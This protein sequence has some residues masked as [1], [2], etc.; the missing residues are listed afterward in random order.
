MDIKQL[1]SYNLGDAVKFHQQLNPRLWT[2]REQ[3]RPEIRQRLLLIAEDF[4]TSLGVSD[5]D[6]RDVT[7]SGSNA[8]Y[9]YTSHSDIDLHLIIDIPEG[10]DTE[11]YRE[12]FNAKKTMYNNEHDITVKGIPVELYVQIADEPVVSNGVYSVLADDWLQIPQRRRA[13]IDDVS[14]RSKYEDLAQ[15]IQHAIDTDSYDVI[16]KLSD[17]IRKMRQSGLEQHGEFGAENLAF[18]ILRSQGDIDKLYK[19]KTRARS[20]EL[21]LRELDRKP[22]SYGFG[23]DYLDEVGLTPDGTNPSTCEFTNESDVVVKTDREIIDD[24]VEFCRN[25]LELARGIKLRLRR[26]PTWSQRNSTFGRYNENTQE[27]EVAV[28]QRHIMDVLRT[29]AHELVHQKQ[30]EIG[31]VPDDAGR[32]G[33]A[34]ENEAN[35]EAG[36]L[37]R[38]YGKQHPELFASHQ[39]AS[40]MT[41]NTNEVMEAS[42]YIPTAAEADDPRYKMALTVDVRPGAIGKAANA[43]MLNTDSQGHPQLANPDGTVKRLAEEFARF[44]L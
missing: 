33:S 8:S 6:L 10:S 32:D 21:S 17:K 13:D 20:Q 11:V 27:L 23:R 1:E 26:D 37:M 22:V 4:Q 7:I 41:E 12:L 19:A 29:L 36:V 30:N 38:R 14:V 25:E 16:S 40:T 18:K 35:A 2:R 31:I 5:I 15:R 9:T 39:T 3:L 24:F 44:K 42:G 34:W 28:G 43:F